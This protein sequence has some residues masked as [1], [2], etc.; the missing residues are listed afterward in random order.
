LKS[1]NRQQFLDRL[2]NNDLLIKVD[3]NHI[4]LKEADEFSDISWCYHAD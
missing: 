1:A 2:R 3:A 4:I